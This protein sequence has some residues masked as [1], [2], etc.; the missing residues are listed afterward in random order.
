VNTWFIAST[1]A[2]STSRIGTSR[3]SSREIDV[4]PR[5][6]IPHGTIRSK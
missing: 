4:T 2:S 3:P 5:S 6:A 1:T